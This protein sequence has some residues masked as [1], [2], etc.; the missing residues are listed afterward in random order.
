[1]TQLLEAAIATVYALPDDQQ[2]EVARLL[3]QLIGVEQ[4]VYVLSP[5]EHADLD[6]SIA[7]EERGEFASDEE[8]A[9]IWA[10]FKR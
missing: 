10:R 8:I 9:A 7:A 6:V 2:D 1:M 4:P 3:L 5:D